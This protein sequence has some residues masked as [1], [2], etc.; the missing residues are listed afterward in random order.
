MGFFFPAVIQNNVNLTAETRSQVK[1]SEEAGDKSLFCALTT[2]H[3]DMQ[4]V[5]TMKKAGII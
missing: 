2:H 3:E 1:K 4:N 5:I